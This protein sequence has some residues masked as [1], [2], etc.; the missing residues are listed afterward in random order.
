MEGADYMPNDIVEEVVTLAEAIKR[1]QRVR[2]KRIFLQISTWA[3]MTIQN[4]AKDTIA[5][6]PGIGACLEVTRKQAVTFLVDAFPPHWQPKL[7]IKLHIGE[8]VLFVGE[9]PR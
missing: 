5:G 8:L 7:S 6:T 1:L 2:N 4:P 9:V 3:R